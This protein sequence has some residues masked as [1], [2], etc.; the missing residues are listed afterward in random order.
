MR[1][2]SDFWSNYSYNGDIVMIILDMEYN[3]RMKIM[4]KNKGEFWSVYRN[5]VDKRA[6]SDFVRH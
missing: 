5:H 3:C 4:I 6:G 1:I 2:S